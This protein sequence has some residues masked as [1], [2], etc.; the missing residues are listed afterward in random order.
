MSQKW[1]KIY[2]QNFGIDG[3]NH[4]LYSLQNVESG[5]C[6]YFGYESNVAYLKYCDNGDRNNY[7]T[8]H[9]RGKVLGHGS[10][11]NKETGEWLTQG[12]GRELVY[13]TSNRPSY[14]F[15]YYRNGDLMNLK[16]GLCV[17]RKVDSF[18]LETRP[19]NDDRKR[20]NY[21]DYGDNIFGFWY[22]SNGGMCLTGGEVGHSDKS[23]GTVSLKSQCT[24]VENQMWEWVEGNWHVPIGEWRKVGCYVNNLVTTRTVSNLESYGV[25]AGVEISNELS[26]GFEVKGIGASSTLSSTVYASM[27]ASWEREVSDSISITQTCPGSKSCLWQWDMTMEHVG[28]P[29]LPAVKWE[30]GSYY[31]SDDTWSPVCPAHSKCA[32]AEC[33]YCEAGLEEPGRNFK[34]IHEKLKRSSDEL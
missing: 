31:C 14:S 18:E 20:F 25:E 3:I 34:D 2:R 29:D 12:L 32:D 24:I 33:R 4:D 19:C 8:F 15:I 1:T 11:R 28:K 26:V 13:L 6:L 21:K 10:L 27:S 7:V 22:Y 30:S 5:D 23:F 17:L 16:T 9:N